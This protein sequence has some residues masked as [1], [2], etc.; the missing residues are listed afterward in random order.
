MKYDKG[1]YIES[2]IYGLDE[3]VRNHQEKLVKC[4]KMHKCVSCERD[5][6]VGEQALC[7]TGFTDDGAVVAYTCLECVEEWLEESGQ[8]D[9]DD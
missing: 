4:R 9:N 5:I 1:L 7:E 6:R 8:V 2:G 3:D